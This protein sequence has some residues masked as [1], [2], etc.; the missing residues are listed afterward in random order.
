MN[1]YNTLRCSGQCTD[2]SDRS[3]RGTDGPPVAQRTDW[4]GLATSTQAMIRNGEGPATATSTHV[5]SR[6]GEGRQPFVRRESQDSPVSRAAAVEKDWEGEEEDEEEDEEEVEIVE[7]EAEDKEEAVTEGGVV[8]EGEVIEKEDVLEAIDAEKEEDEGKE[9][10]G[11]KEMDVE[12]D[13]APEPEADDP[14]HLIYGQRGSKA[15]DSSILLWNVPSTMSELQVAQILS[16][17]FPSKTEVETKWEGGPGLERVHVRFP[18]NWD[19]NRCFERVQAQAKLEGWVAKPSRPFKKRVRQRRGRPPRTRPDE[20]AALKFLARL[21]F[22]LPALAAGA[23]GDNNVAATQANGGASPPRPH[24]LPPSLPL[25]P[26]PPPPPQPRPPTPPQPRPPTPPPLIPEAPNSSAN[27]IIGKRSAANA[28]LKLGTFNINGLQNKAAEL[29]AHLSKEK[30]DIIGLCETKLGGGKLPVIKGYRLFAGKQSSAGGV[31][32]LVANHI[33]ASVTALRQDDNNQLWIRVAGSRGEKNLLICVAYMPQSNSSNANVAFDILNSSTMRYEEDGSVVLLGD[34]NA[35]LGVPGDEAEELKIGPHG[36][37]SRQRN[38]NGD[39]LME[40]LRARNLRSLNGFSLPPSGQGSFWYTRREPSMNGATTMIDYVLASVDL[41]V[42]DF[43]VDYTDLDS[44]HHLVRATIECTRRARRRRGRRRHKRYNCDKFYSGPKVSE[45]DARESRECFEQQLSLHFRDFSLPEP[46]DIP[47]ADADA[48]VSEKTSD[49][50]RRILEAAECSV[51]SRICAKDFM[52]SWWDDEVAKAVEHRRKVYQRL[53]RGETTWLEYTRARSETRKLVRQKKKEDWDAFLKQLPASGKSAHM[54]QVWGILS[55]LTSSS[56]KRQ[57]PTPILRPDG[58]LATSLEDRCEAWAAYMAE[59]GT[60]SEDPSF[61]DEFARAVEGKEEP[62]SPSPPA[63]QPIAHSAGSS[64]AIAAAGQVQAAS[65]SLSDSDPTFSDDDIESSSPLQRPPELNDPFQSC[66]IEA[67]LSKMKLG[68]ASGADKVSNEMLKA[69][70]STMSSLLLSLFNWIN[71]VSVVPREWGTAN[72]TTLHKKGDVR[73][74][75]N[76]RTIS[77]I[78]C[79]AKTYLAVWASRLSAHMEPRLGEEQGGFRPGRTTMDQLYT[80]HE[81]L[82][83]RKRDGKP[84]F[85]FFIDFKK[86]FDKVWHAG[87][88]KKMQEYGIGGKALQIVKSLYRDIRLSVL[89]DGIPARAVPVKQGVRQ[90]CP[91]SPVLFAIFVEELASQLRQ[92]GGVELAGRFLHCLL[93]ADDIVLVADSPEKLQD[94]INVVDAFCKKW[95]MT[96]HP[97]KSKVMVV[98]QQGQDVETLRT[99]IVSTLPEEAE[100]EEA[101]EVAEAAQTD[102]CDAEELEVGGVEEEK[103]EMASSADVDSDPS[104]ADVGNPTLFEWHWRGT[105][106]GVVETYEYLGMLLSYDLSWAPHLKKLVAKCKQSNVGLGRILNTRAVPTPLKKLVWN[107]VVRSKL[108]YGCTLYRPNSKQATA[109]ESIQHVA[110]TRMLSLN[111]HTSRFA[112]RTLV[113]FKSS[114]ADRRRALR[115]RLYHSLDSMKRSR[116]PSHLFTLPKIKSKIRGPQPGHWPSVVAEEVDDARL[117]ERV[118]D[119]R[120]KRHH[121]AEL[122]EIQNEELSVAADATPIEWK[123]AVDVWLTEQDNSTASGSELLKRFRAG[124]TSGI[125]PLASR[126]LANGADVLRTRFLSGAHALHSFIGR[127][128]KFAHEADASMLNRLRSSK[129]CASCQ[130]PESLEHF[131]LICNKEKLLKAISAIERDCNC[132]KSCAAAFHSTNKDDATAKQLFVLGAPTNA[133]LCDATDRTL[134]QYLTE[135]WSDRNSALDKI[136][137]QERPDNDEE[138]QLDA[139]PSQRSI[140]DFFAVARNNVSGDGLVAHGPLATL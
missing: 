119:S 97:G 11:D 61:D 135:I 59:L 85:L 138:L 91:L 76:Y 39:R 69:G 109:L 95:R 83:R 124:C 105:A 12:E 52:R 101:A 29:E 117:C 102:R 80:L 118:Q 18:N 37:A 78:S 77:L 128:S 100:E 74:P 134:R 42:S 9:K 103:A 88:F 120:S 89:V 47:E 90:G 93:Y 19:R 110:G 35:W 2:T 67:I 5:P 71:E 46:S 14:W 121:A 7:T 68:K 104:S 132:E 20:R 111:R 129:I 70:G 115:M 53:R 31:A 8:V 87:L 50:V 13:D 116:W 58:S 72:V 51:G 136:S 27:T 49:F 40:L 75:G 34:M 28:K 21:R 15:D 98:P 139:D 17:C 10:N 55:R 84:S 112:V 123:K 23:D 3:K 26:R 126:C 73:D 86:A 30:L 107:S 125:T 1:K 60:R 96:L 25:P 64:A 92:I 24:S 140:L 94:M 41:P 38:R 33:V 48:L 99:R 54:K 108:D 127:Y 6:F 63:P 62:S 131:L 32:M 81:S 45:V 16:P 65:E 82:L 106:L 44:D 113:G 114:L 122:D 79:V 66:E 137:A 56:S 43:S 36:D 22:Q 4:T 133:T 130:A 57:A